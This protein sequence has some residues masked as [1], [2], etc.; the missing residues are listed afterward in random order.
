MYTF[1]M[2]RC[3][4]RRFLH[5]TLVRMLVPLQHH[6]YCSS[7]TS[8]H[9]HYCPSRLTMNSWSTRKVVHSVLHIQLLIQHGPNHLPCFLKNKL[10]QHRIYR[11]KFSYLKYPWFE[12]LYFN[13]KNKNMQIRLQY[14]KNTNCSLS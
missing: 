2:F 12:I 11:E 3:T 6:S 1:L 13:D 5:T 9:S 8:T 14:Y 4:L 10:N 7:A